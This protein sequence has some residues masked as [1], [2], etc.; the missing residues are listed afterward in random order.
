MRK[1][2]AGQVLRVSSQ[3]QADGHRLFRSVESKL[4]GGGSGGVG[5]R[6]ATGGP[7]KVGTM[8]QISETLPR[9]LEKGATLP[10][11]HVSSALRQRYGSGNEIVHGCSQASVGC[12]YAGFRVLNRPV[13]LVFVL[14]PL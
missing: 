11:C 14:I 7:R 1:F 10:L 2:V 5:C 12:N 6:H 3:L 8:G 4:F 9:L 13:V